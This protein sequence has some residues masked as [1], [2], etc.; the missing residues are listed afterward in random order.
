M[1]PK[2]KGLKFFDKSGQNQKFSIVTATTTYLVSSIQVGLPTCNLLTYL[3]SSF[4]AV[5]NWLA[6][7]SN[8]YNRDGG[9]SENK[10][11]D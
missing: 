8:I 2:Y 11:G 6:L 10:G 9:R 5:F 3:L 7:P 4:N 1:F